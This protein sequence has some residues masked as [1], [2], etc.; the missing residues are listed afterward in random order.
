M[1]TFSK[2]ASGY[3]IRDFASCPGT[4]QNVATSLGRINPNNVAARNQTQRLAWHQAVTWTQAD[5]N[6][7]LKQT[8]LKAK[9]NSI[10]YLFWLESQYRLWKK[11]SGLQIY[12]ENN[13][14]LLSEYFLLSGYYKIYK[15]YFAL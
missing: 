10:K 6:L 7:L 13:L 14:Y 1:D 12:K 9:I 11:V 3:P 15:A 4:E 8:Y 2:E 5:W